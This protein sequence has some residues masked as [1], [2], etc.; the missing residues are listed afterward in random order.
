MVA[1]TDIVSDF[2]SA[3]LEYENNPHK[4]LRELLDEFKKIMETYTNLYDVDRRLRQH[5]RAVL[6]TEFPEENQE[7]FRHGV[8][9]PYICCLSFEFPAGPPS[10]DLDDCGGCM[11][12]L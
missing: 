12:C 4:D 3:V 7:I 8:P 10:N 1:G 6:K 5:T 9:R 2:V 11:I